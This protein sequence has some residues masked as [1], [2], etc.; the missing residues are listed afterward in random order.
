[1]WCWIWF[2]FIA[3]ITK[4]IVLSKPIFSLSFSATHPQ[5]RAQKQQL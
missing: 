4:H 3:Y 5:Y 2:F 1:M